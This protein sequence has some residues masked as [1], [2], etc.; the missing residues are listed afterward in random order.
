MKGRV[1]VLGGPLDG[2]TVEVDH[3]VNH[4]DIVKLDGAEYVFKFVGGRP[5]FSWEV[6]HD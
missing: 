1:P 3:R 6:R 5:R 2:A 4:G